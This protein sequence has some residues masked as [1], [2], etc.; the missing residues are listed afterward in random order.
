MKS[1]RQSHVAWIFFFFY[2]NNN[3]KNHCS[4]IA[5]RIKFSETVFWMRA[6]LF[7]VMFS[8]WYKLSRTM[9]KPTKWHVRPAKALINLGIR[10]IW[11]GAFAARLK[12]VWVKRTTKTQIRLGGCSGLP[13]S[14]LGA[15]AILLE[16]QAPA[17]IKNKIRKQEIPPFVPWLHQVSR[18]W[19][20]A[21]FRTS[22]VR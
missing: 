9:T 15:N 1:A 16:F 2:I 6:T 22:G 17:Q 10:P 19:M 8:W 18:F 7:V 4:W 21:R 5:S 11:L 14:S 13:E 3:N 12:K 20:H